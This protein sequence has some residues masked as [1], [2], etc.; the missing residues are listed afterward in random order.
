MRGLRRPSFTISVG[1]HDRVLHDAR[2]YRPERRLRGRLDGEAV[3]RERDRCTIENVSRRSRRSMPLLRRPTVERRRRH[4][5]IMT[6]RDAPEENLARAD[7]LW[8]ALSLFVTVLFF[9]GLAAY[10]YWSGTGKLPWS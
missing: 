9:L 10:L 1:E 7:G 5:T 6:D 2:R 4:E 8:T 3:N